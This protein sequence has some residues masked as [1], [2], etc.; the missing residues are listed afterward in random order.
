MNLNKILS[1]AKYAL[2][3]GD[4]QE[5]V[6]LFKEAI[7]KGDKKEGWIGLAEA[8][9]LLNDLSS[10]I[11]SYHKVL[12]IDSQNKKAKDKIEELAERLKG[13]QAKKSSHKTG[14]KAEGDY[15]YIKTQ[16]NWEKFLIK[17]INLG[18]SLP[19]YF[20]GEYP[21]KM[22][23]YL[24]WFKLIHE[25]GMN[26][27][28]VYA[29]QSPDFY[30]ALYEFNQNAPKLFLLQGIW[31]EPKNADTIDDGNFLLK[32]RSH[33]KEV[34]DAIHGNTTMLERPG[35]P[36]GR[37]LWDVSPFLLGYLFGREPEACLVKDYNERHGRKVQDFFGKYLYIER[38]NPFE[39]WNT[40]ILDYL[41]T[42]SY[43]AYRHLPLVSV[44]NWITL[45]PLEH[46]TETNIEDEELYFTGRKPDIKRCN[47][48]EDMEVLDTYK[49]K[50]TFNCFFSSYHI[51]PYY[52]DFMNYEF[53][54]EKRPYLAYLRRLK[55]HH[56]GQPLVVA[57][58]GIPTSRAS[59]HWHSQGW[60]HGGKNEIEQ[61]NI[62]LQ[63]IDDIKKA[64]YAGYVI[65]SWTDEWF[66]VNWLFMKYYMPRD[67]KPL[68]FN[69][70]DPEENY[71]LFEVYPGY[72][73]KIVS[74]EGNLEEWEEAFIAHEKTKPIKRA[75]EI[76][77]V[78]LTHD[79]GFLY[80]LIEALEE[81]DFKRVNFLVGIDTGHQEYG[82]FSFPLGIDLR[83]PVG[84]KFLVHFA[85]KDISRLLIASS[86]NKMLS[87]GKFFSQKK[88]VF[89][90]KSFEGKWSLIV[91]KNNMRRITK[92]F[93]KF[94]GPKFFNLSCLRFGSLNPENPDFDTLA[95][96][97]VKD[98]LIE[99][100]LPWEL[101]NFSDPSSRKM[102]W[103]EGNNLHKE[104]DGV[105]LLAIS[106]IPD[107]SNPPKALNL[108]DFIPNPLTKDKI[109]TYLWDG[110][111]MPSFHMRLKKS[112]Y[113]LKRF[114]LNEG[115]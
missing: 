64:Q 34:V 74:L 68:W 90:Q 110:W 70:Q 100:R 62:L 77:S 61:A 26:T 55:E 60:T 112:Y 108:L 37:Y 48:N 83:S 88:E 86:Y 13:L 84:L 39:V 15:I 109:K 73:K 104:S 71:G 75:G 85:G 93:K 27:I 107:P 46:P 33:L 51:Y 14:F 95:D 81:V 12:E 101:L 11:W 2:R 98:N 4:Y 111:E 35:L 44:V 69:L 6:N 19:G 97:Y 114:L 30:Q 3:K 80:I 72:P 67:R 49:I 47:E 40:K 8:Y 58:F 79:E 10:A 52:P 43:E 92:D 53:L 38:G 59:A 29:L 9:D 82:E 5:A 7:N 94:F 41:L 25:M 78:R 57:E 103:K 66:K 56:K 28:R 54:D 89:P 99:I 18:L 106:F 63:M 87:D 32:I 23:T 22:E 76:K 105:R 96:F 50:S 36:A 91:A 21:I 65:F 42:Y 20:P 16:K 115:I 17:G 113:I 45:D 24:K 31:Y 102:L 1:S